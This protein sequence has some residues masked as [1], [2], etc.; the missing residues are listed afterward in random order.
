MPDFAPEVDEL[1]R[2]AG[3]G[4]PKLPAA[5]PTIQRLPMVDGGRYT[6]AGDLSSTR[7]DNHLP[8][9]ERAFSKAI[10]I[11]EKLSL[12]DSQHGLASGCIWPTRIFGWSIFNGGWTNAMKRKRPLLARWKSMRRRTAEIAAGRGSNEHL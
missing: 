9:A 2:R 11:L 7:M 10:E 12:A 3:G 6:A 1:N 8:T 4:D 5:F